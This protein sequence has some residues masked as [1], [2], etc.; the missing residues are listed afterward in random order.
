VSTTGCAPAADRWPQGGQHG[1]RFQHTVQAA[2][3]CLWRRAV[4]APEKRVV[5]LPVGTPVLFR[6][7][8][9]N[10]ANA[11]SAV[12][13]SFQVPSSRD[14]ICWQARHAECALQCL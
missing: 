12:A 2:Q 3:V 10:A 4:Q 1:P 11:N 7:P 8:N 5:K 13:I 6:E 9:P 14:R